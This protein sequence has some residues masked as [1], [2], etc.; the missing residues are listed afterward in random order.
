MGSAKKHA[1]SQISQQSSVSAKATT[2]T[3]M[4]SSRLK[5]LHTQHTV[6]N[7]G[8]VRRRGKGGVEMC[9]RLVLTPW[10]W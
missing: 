4:L 10:E 3:I 5:Y 6:A 2:C 1:I 9:V 8:R 7:G